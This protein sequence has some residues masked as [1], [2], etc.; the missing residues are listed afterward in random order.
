M[1]VHFPRITVKPHLFNG[2]YIE[3]GTALQY[4]SA[5]TH[6]N[7]KIYSDPSEFRPNRWLNECKDIDSLC[8]TGFGLGSRSCIGQNLAHIESKIA[9]YCFFKRYSEVG[10][11]DNLPIR[12]GFMAEAENLEIR[13]KKTQ[14]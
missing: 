4:I 1:P 2:V 6:F 9:S 13:V 11:P 5:A 3:K 7:P 12:W 14:K 10:V 8:L